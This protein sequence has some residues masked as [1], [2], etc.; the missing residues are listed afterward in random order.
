MSQQNSFVKLMEELSIIN[1]NSIE[2]L[3]SISDLLSTSDNS[4][5]VDWVTKDNSGNYTN[6]TFEMPTIGYLKSQIDILNQ[7]IKKMTG[8]EGGTSSSYIIDGKSTKKIYQ[9]DLNQEPMPINDLNGISIFESK[10]NWFFE[11]LINPNIS[12]TIDLTD[13]IN[14]TNKKVLVRR[15]II[16]FQKGN[17]DQLTE[18]G[19]ISQNSFIDTFINKTDIKYDTFINWHLGATGVVDNLDPN[20][21]LDEQIY[22][23]NLQTLNDVGFFSVLKTEDDTIRKKFWY[24]LNTLTYKNKNGLNKELTINDELIINKKETSTRYKVIEVSKASSTPKILVERLEGYDPIPIGTDILKIYSSSELNKNVNIGVGYDEY[25]VIFIKSINTDNNIVS[26]IWSQGTAFYTN[27]LVLNSDSTVSLTNYYLDEVQDYGKLLQD[28]VRRQT[29]TSEAIIPNKTILENDNFKV[30]QINKHLTD[31]GISKE[32]KDLH[33]RKESVKSRLNQINDSIIEKN[34]ELNIKQYKSVGEKNKSTNELDRLIT[35]QESETKQYSSIVNQMSNISTDSSILPKYRLRG[36]FDIPQA[37]TIGNKLQDIIAFKIQYRYSAT[38]GQTN[39]VESFEIKPT[40][41]LEDLAGQQGLTINTDLLTEPN[42]K[43]DSSSQV[44][45]QDNSIY[46]SR[47]TKINA[48]SIGIVPSKT[49]TVITTASGQEM[50]LSKQTILQTKKTDGF[51]S[52][53]KEYITKPRERR[54][55]ST[56]NEWYWVVEDVSDA[57]APNINQIDIPIKQNESI[58][59]RIKSISEVG[60]PDTLIESEWSDIIKLDFPSELSNITAEDESITLQNSQ[61]SVR[62]DFNNELES[63]GVYRHVRD[64]FTQNDNYI[65]H[66]DKT[67]STSFRDEQGNLINLFDYLD[68]LTTKIS[69]LEEQVSRSKGELVV[70]LFRG[71]EETEIGNNSETNI[72]VECEDYGELSG[73]TGERIYYNNIYVIKDYYISLKNVAQ[74][75]PLGLFS[76]RLYTNGGTNTFFQYPNDVSCYIDADGYLHAQEDN[77]F[78]WFS[79]NHNGNKLYSGTTDISGSTVLLNSDGETFGSNLGLSGSTAEFRRDCY[80]YNLMDSDTISWTEI[81]GTPITNK[82]NFLSS[83]YPLIKDIDNLIDTS[84]EKLKLLVGQEEMIIPINC[85]FKFDGTSGD[86]WTLDITEMPIS[87]ILKRPLKMFVETEN[88]IRP[89]Q[90]TLIFNMKQHRTA[91]YTEG[92]MSQ[93]PT[94]GK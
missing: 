85:Y 30:V 13:K 52:N 21:F 11:S 69:S 67:L 46:V 10:T 70:T 42:L 14:D 33:T 68:L 44:I 93:S 58:E 51:F 72:I 31:N 8:S 43:P 24:H 23:I 74:T 39:P 34:K 64:S 41:N 71:T 5:T 17:F 37:Q 1:K 6:S 53:W 61:E 66:N 81:P 18:S 19:R 50:I 84:Q 35:Q 27:D 20:K 60:W 16:K 29:P 88:S 57:D 54:F 47:E 26:S 94:Q 59:I 89:F 2:V 65:A 36:F 15:H 7:N 63:K 25:N 12:V 32:K 79:D 78:I 3:S 86:T 87:R 76:D 48:P 28:L 92:N 80:D 9:V 75:N 38:D 83:V 62:V 40:V 77:Q 45:E 73:S 91:N 49:N 55:D 56:T 90:F 82:N 22:D 4:V